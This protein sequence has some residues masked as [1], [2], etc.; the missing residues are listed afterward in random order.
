MIESHL[1]QKFLVCTG[2]VGKDTRPLS[3]THLNNARLFLA[4][5]LPSSCGAATMMATVFNDHKDED[6]F[7]Y[8]TYSG[9]NTFGG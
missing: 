4:S 7:L 8:I 5:L 1:Q 9:E 3:L 6:G 2:G